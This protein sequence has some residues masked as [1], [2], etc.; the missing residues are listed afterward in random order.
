MSRISIGRRGEIDGGK[1][2]MSNL[3]SSNPLHGWVEGMKIG[4]EDGGGYSL[5]RRSEGEKKKGIWKK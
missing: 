2:S 4:S 5:K 1:T 3:I